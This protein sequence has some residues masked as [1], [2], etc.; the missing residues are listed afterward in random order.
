MKSA[1]SLCSAQRTPVALDN[2]LGI[3]P[4]NKGYGTAGPIVECVPGRAR[5]G[6][7]QP[8]GSAALDADAKQSDFCM[9]LA[10][11]VPGGLSLAAIRHRSVR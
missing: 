9:Y 10:V 3:R 8:L 11:I 4:L 1:G 6:V 2:V 5:R 7:A